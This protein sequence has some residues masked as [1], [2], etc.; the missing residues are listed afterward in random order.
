MDEITLLKNVEDYLRRYL[1]SKKSW[2]NRIPELRGLK[3]AL[4]MLDEFRLTNRSN[5]DTR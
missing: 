5:K 4:R 2:N 1:E 3:Y